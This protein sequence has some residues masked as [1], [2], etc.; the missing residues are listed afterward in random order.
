MTELLTEKYRATKSF[1]WNYFKGL[2]KLQNLESFAIST[3]FLLQKMVS[4]TTTAL[5]KPKLSAWSASAVNSR[6]ITG[7][8][9]HHF[10]AVTVCANCTRFRPFNAP[11]SIWG[12]IFGVQEKQGIPILASRFAA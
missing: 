10:F 4:G 2:R 8:I 1:K 7:M 12:S 9:R 3:I 5:S 11:S 6:K